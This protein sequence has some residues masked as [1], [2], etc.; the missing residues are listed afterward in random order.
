MP[1]DDL[2][3][4]LE[5]VHLNK[6]YEEVVAIILE[7]ELAFIFGP[8]EAKGQLEKRLEHAH[9]KGRVVVLE[10]ADHTTGPQIIANSGTTILVSLKQAIWVLPAQSA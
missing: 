9:Y 3:Q 6:Y 5:S 4:N 10:P 7:T 1:G 8:G 2:R